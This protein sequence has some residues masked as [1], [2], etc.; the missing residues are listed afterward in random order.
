MERDKN[1]HDGIIRIDVGQVVRDRSPK[2]SR[3]IP[4]SVIRWLE[5]LICQDDLN[6]ILEE[7]AGKTGAEFCRGVLK[8]LDVKIEVCYP[9]RLPSKD[10][11]RVVFVSNHPLGGLDGIAL[12]DMVQRHYGGQVWFVVNDLLMAVK[13]LAGVFLPI[14]KLGKQ[15]RA[16]LGH[17][18]EAFAGND[19]I[20]IFPA[21]LVSRYRKIPYNGEHIRTVCDLPWQKMFVNKCVS[22]R[23][24]IVPLFFSGENSMDFYKKANLRKRLGLRFNIE[25][26]LLPREMIRSS[27]K[28]FTVKV[29]IT[30][31]YATICGGKDA[32]GYALALGMEVFMLRSEQCGET[33]PIPE[34]EN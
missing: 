7:N 18:E 30:K 12:I 29:G 17:I 8:S 25:Q 32:A 28:T 16:S 21:G 10:N 15:S 22:H 1:I 5:R 9:E 23:R 34:P 24:D 20:I 4:K 14:N 2:L 19:P 6:R 31:P 11:R 33:D 3:F 13:P 27:G 26:V